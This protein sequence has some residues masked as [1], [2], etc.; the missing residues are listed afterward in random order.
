MAFYLAFPFPLFSDVLPHHAGHTHSLEHRRCASQCV[1]RMGLSM[2]SA[3][4]LRYYKR[5]LPPPIHHSNPRLA[6]APERPLPD[7]SSQNLD[8]INRGEF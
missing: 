2:R 5:P 8:L 7:S 4:A 1:L 3:E 6:R